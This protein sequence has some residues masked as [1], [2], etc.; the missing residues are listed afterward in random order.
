M[1]FVITI[2]GVDRTSSVEA[3]SLRKSDTLNQQVDTLE[4]SVNKYG[5]L[6]YVPTLGHEIVVTRDG[7]TIFG[8]VIV[9]ISNVTNGTPILRYRVKCADYSQYLKRQLVTERYNNMTVAAI[10]ADLVAPTPRTASP[11]QNAG[12]HSKSRRSHSIVSPLP[13]ASRSSQMRSPTSGTWTM[14]RTSTSSQGIARRRHSTSRT[15]PA[16]TS[17]I[18]WR[19]SK[20]SRRSE[21]ASRSREERPRALLRALNCSPVMPHASTLL[22][23]TST[24]L[25]RQSPSAVRL[26]R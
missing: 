14:T 12:A 11:L 7:T 15:L 23:P 20:T 10:I 18:R 8:G 9:R 3:G 24:P 5:S 4:L 25:S 1:S 26:R 6:S 13:T 21:T 16:T 2:N 22:L 17:S 19:S